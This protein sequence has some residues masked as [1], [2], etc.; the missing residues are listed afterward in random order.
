MLKKSKWNKKQEAYEQIRNQHNS[1][2]VSIIHNQTNKQSP[3][4]QKEKMKNIGSEDEQENTQK[5]YLRSPLS[6]KDCWTSQCSPSG[7]LSSLLSFLFRFSSL[8][9]SFLSACSCFLSSWSFPSFFFSDCYSRH[10]LF[11]KQ[12][13]NVP[14]TCP[15]LPKNQQRNHELLPLF[16]SSLTN[17][18][19]L[20]KP[21]SL[22]Q[23]KPE[24]SSSLSTCPSLCATLSVTNQQQVKSHTPRCLFLPAQKGV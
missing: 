17:F 12:P 16:F 20:L 6:S 22:S 21:P 23:T 3:K 5:K 14:A 1:H 2:V 7:R 24:K 15:S 4:Q 18:F 11:L 13:K 19:L 9:F 10:A 8:A